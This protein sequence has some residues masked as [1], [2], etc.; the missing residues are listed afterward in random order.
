MNKED[1][2]LG[3]MVR[4]KLLHHPNVTFAAYKVPHPLFA[5]FELRVQ[6]DGEVTPKEALKSACRELI[7]EIHTFRTRFKAAYELTK[8]SKGQ[9]GDG[10]N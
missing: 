4:D 7:G 6:T 9:N 10:G 5:K 8:M 2:T 1:H 3:N